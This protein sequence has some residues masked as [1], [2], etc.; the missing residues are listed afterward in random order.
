VNLGKNLMSSL[1]RGFLLWLIIVID[2]SSAL[3]LYIVGIRIK[4]LALY[5]LVLILV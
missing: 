2:S 4:S 5:F 1:C 3:L